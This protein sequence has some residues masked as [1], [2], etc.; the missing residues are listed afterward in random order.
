MDQRTAP[1]NHVILD[2]RLHCGSDCQCKHCIVADESSVCSFCS[3][4]SA[5]IRLLACDSTICADLGLRSLIGRGRRH[6]AHINCRLATHH[7]SHMMRIV[8]A[9]LC[10]PAALS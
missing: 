10:L 9:I 1:H 3:V 6:P 4:L 2:L 5:C 8:F 7:G